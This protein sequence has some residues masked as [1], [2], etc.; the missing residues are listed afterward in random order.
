MTDTN[1]GTDIAERALTTE[2]DDLSEDSRR[3]IADQIRSFLI[4]VRDI[5]AQP[6][7]EDVDGGSPRCRTCCSKISQLLLARSGRLQGVRRLRAGGRYETDAG[8]DPDLDEMR[9]RLAELF[10]GLDEYAEVFDPYGNPP[11]INVFRISDDLTAIAND[12]VHGLAHYEAG[13]M[14]E[15]L[16]WW[17]FSYACPTWGAAAS[18]VL[19]AIQ[20]LI[21]HDRLEPAHD[22]RPRPS[23]ASSSRSPTRRSRAAEPLSRSQAEHQPVHRIGDDPVERRLV[24]NRAVRQG[25]QALPRVAQTSMPGFSGSAPCLTGGLALA[26]RS[27][28]AENARSGCLVQRSG[29]VAVL[30]GEHQLEQCGVRSRS[31]RRRRANARHPG[32][33][34]GTAS[35]SRHAARRRGARTASAGA[36]SSAWRSKWRRGAA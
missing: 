5:A 3:Q 32:R 24:D 4:T 21:A 12:L 25:G 17:Q 19:R 9:D 2:A 33:R 7:E 8:P 30:A 36:S 22:R 20:S 31:G 34:A 16:W 23:T 29:Q 13:R 6:D 26:I 28:I 14:D 15:A 27:D 18:A 35:A 11:E 10:E 1:S